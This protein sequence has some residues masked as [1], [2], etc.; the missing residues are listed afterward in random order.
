MCTLKQITIATI[1][2]RK[3]NLIF[4]I[5]SDDDSRIQWHT[6]SAVPLPCGELNSFL[7][8]KPNFKSKSSTS[9]VLAVF[10]FFWIFSVLFSNSFE[11]C[12]IFSSFDVF[13]L[14]KTGSFCF[15]ILTL[16]SVGLSHFEKLEFTCLMRHFAQ[17]FH[18]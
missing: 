11:G 3:I 5:I 8:S 17:I 2:E 15:W 4:K 16:A 18:C 10:L 12:W 6:W 13:D 7:F 1:S 9:L 14:G